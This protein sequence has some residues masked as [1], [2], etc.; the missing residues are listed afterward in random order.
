MAAETAL[1]VFSWMIV[2]CMCLHVYLVKLKYVHNLFQILAIL[3]GS[4]TT[5][6]EANFLSLLTGQSYHVELIPPKT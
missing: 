3:V 5:N 6:E 4:G 2:A 1:D